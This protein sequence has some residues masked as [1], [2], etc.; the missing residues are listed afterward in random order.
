M[1]TARTTPEALF[2]DPEDAKLYILTKTDTGVSQLFQ[3]PGP[4]PAG[5]GNVAMTEA[6]RL[7]FGQGALAG[8]PL[9]TGGDISPGGDM[10]AVRTYVGVF[11]WRRSPGQPF[12]QAL[13]SAPCSAPSRTE[14]QGE[15]V[16]FAADSQGYFTVSEG[17]S[18]SVHFFARK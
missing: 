3:S 7:M 4:L 10:I 2:V 6:T 12:A 13:H 11:V 8:S 15:S 16:G 18:Q 9:V 14:Q 1:L 17:S 5:G